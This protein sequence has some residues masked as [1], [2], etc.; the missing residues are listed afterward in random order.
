M[1]FPIIG[2]TSVW[3]NWNNFGDGAWNMWFMAPYGSWIYAGFVKDSTT[4]F[5]KIDIGSADSNYEMSDW[6]FG[7]VADTPE[8]EFTYE[9]Q[10]GY[11]DGSMGMGCIRGATPKLYVVGRSAPVPAVNTILQKFIVGDGFELESPGT[12]PLEVGGGS[13]LNVNHIA[14]LEVDQGNAY[15]VVLNNNDANEFRLYRYGYTWDGGSH[16]PTH[17]VDL[18]AVSPAQSFM[19]NNT[20]A[21]IRGIG[22]AVDGNIVLFINSGL[23]ATGCKVLK[24]DKDDLSYL[25]QTTWAPSVST[26]TWGYM[27]ESAEVFMWFQGLDSLSSLDWRNAVY[28]DGATA[29]PSQDKSNFIIANNLTTFGSDTA[30]ELQYAARDAFNI[31][32]PSI[33]T[34]FVI[35][36]EDPTDPSSWNDR[37]GGIQDLSGDPFF[38]GDGV[39]L[40]IQAITTTDSGG[41]AKAYYKPMRSGSGTEIDI[42]RIYCPSDS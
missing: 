7:L 11:P 12:I 23:S 10:E 4:Y 36:G 19:E 21:R 33:N 26:S 3:S 31:V 24:F 2:T 5:K 1:S 38:D 35:D 16:Q 34:K 17:D 13:I 42:I 37:I 39:P 28:Y 27:V 6:D 41:V 30:I 20:S 8:T 18:S 9:H 22:R 32:I 15:Y 29:I 25:G 40:A 14:G